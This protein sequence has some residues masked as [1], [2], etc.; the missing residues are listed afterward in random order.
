MAVLVLLYGCEL[1]AQATEMW[2]FIEGER[3]C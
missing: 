2:L 1:H 3:V